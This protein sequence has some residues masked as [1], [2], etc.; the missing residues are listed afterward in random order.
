VRLRVFPREGSESVLWETPSP[1][2]IKCLLPSP[3]YDEVA[4]LWS[5]LQERHDRRGT[6]YLESR[7]CVSVVSVGQSEAE[8]IAPDL[9][10]EFL[11]WRDE[12]T[13]SLLTETRSEGGE[14]RY[15]EW[16]MDLETKQRSKVQTSDS[17]R[18]WLHSG[19][20]GPIQVM[21]GLLAEGRI[22]VRLTDEHIDPAFEGPTDVL[23]ALM[24]EKTLGW[25]LDRERIDVAV[26]RGAGIPYRDPLSVNTIVPPPVAA[27]SPDGRYVALTQLL[28][29][30]AVLVMR[31][32]TGTVID[33]IPL[34]RI[35]GESSPVVL[36]MCWAPD[37]KRFTFTEGHSNPARFYA[38]DFGPRPVPTEWTQLVRMYALHGGH[39]TTVVAGSKARLVPM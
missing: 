9:D 8:Q 6:P 18:S 26:V 11:L 37:S 20:E 36:D 34:T 24:A 16:R 38:P 14:S 31:V 23:E 21:E 22:G 2:R 13:L 33:V 25:P 7:G 19:F 17:P 15:T 5:A 27:V 28:P 32:D 29:L 35:F 10:V 12:R 1:G 39:A 3:S 30:S 4:I